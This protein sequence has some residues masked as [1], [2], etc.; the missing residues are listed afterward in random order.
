MVTLKMALNKFQFLAM[1]ISSLMFLSAVDGG[2]SK[3]FWKRASKGGGGYPGFFKHFPFGPFYSSILVLNGFHAT[4]F[5]EN[6]L[7]ISIFM[8]RLYN[9]R[10]GILDCVMGAVY[11]KYRIQEYNLYSV[12]FNHPI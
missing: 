10:E 7:L 5:I 3:Y 4:D 11:G 12:Y 2:K 6:V 8:I 9:W 1:I